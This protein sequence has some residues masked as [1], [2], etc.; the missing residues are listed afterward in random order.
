MEDLLAGK[1][2]KYRGYSVCFECKQANNP[3]RLLDDN[4]V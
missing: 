3:C 1:E 2:P 4:H